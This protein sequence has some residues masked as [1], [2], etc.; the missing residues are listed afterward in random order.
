M[1]ATSAFLHLDA[2]YVVYGAGA[3]G[4]AFVD[5]LLK[6]SNATIVLVDKQGQ[7]GGHW[8]SAYSFV[9]LH[10]ASNYYGVNSKPLERTRGDYFSLA[11]RSEILA[12]YEEVLRDFMASGR[13]RYFPMCVC[14][15]PFG[16]RVFHSLVDK[17]VV[18]RVTDRA[19]IV[20]ATYMATIGPSLSNARE[21]YEVADTVEVVPPNALPQM[22]Q[23]YDS[24][25]IVG[26]G[27]TAM[28]SIIWLLDSSVNTSRISWIMPRDSWL[29]IREN[30]TPNGM[31]EL[32]LDVMLAAQSAA[33]VEELFLHWENI[34]FVGRIDQSV[35]PMMNHCAIAA[36]DE[37]EKLRRVTSI[38]RM[39]HVL[40][41]EPGQVT[42]QGGVL[43]VPGAALYVDCSKTPI[44]PHPPV[45][46]FDGSTIVLQT[47]AKCQQVFSAALIAHIEI[48]GDD[49]DSKNEL[50]TPVPHPETSQD[51]VHRMIVSTRNKHAWR[52]A[53]LDSWL[54]RSRLNLEAHVPDF[55]HNMKLLW[56]LLRSDYASALLRGGVSGVEAR[57][58]ESLERL[59]DHQH[60]PHGGPLREEAPQGAPRR[61]EAPQGAPPRR[62]EAPV[63][64]CSCRSARS[65]LGASGA[66]RSVRGG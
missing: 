52:E 35:T 49:E 22:Q 3:M 62:E 55:R 16:S 60:S 58:C 57:F 48:R 66:W 51:F 47:I 30:V 33:S 15:N 9:K 45:K 14:D 13:V 53:G 41:V 31:S 11:S 24:Y 64:K 44:A 29:M 20:N 8:N 36:A 1:A 12:Y 23:S 26:A 39:G 50:C 65:G 61:E 6:E 4:M 10:Q 5:V 28:D 21:R 19:K 34:G 18:Y 25:V 7:P 46:V 27:K 63:V 17:Q 38:V 43:S 32:A 59:L 56:G 42:L 37:L 40:R 54:R 2:D